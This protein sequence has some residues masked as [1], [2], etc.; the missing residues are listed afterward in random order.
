MT[1]D[2][3]YTEQKAAETEAVPECGDDIKMNTLT[4]LIFT[5]SAVQT[6]FRALIMLLL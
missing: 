3:L 1:T 2:M 6:R 4:V 5:Q